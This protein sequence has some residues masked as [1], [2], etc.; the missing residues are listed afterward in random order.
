LHLTN[1]QVHDEVML[2]GPRES[3]EAAK[4]RV[5]A[6]MA[7][8]WENLVGYVGKPLR[9]DLA[10]DANIADTWYEAK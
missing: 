3:S 9:V 10:V 5:V 8:P 6:C 7:N 1:L 2:E 4:Q